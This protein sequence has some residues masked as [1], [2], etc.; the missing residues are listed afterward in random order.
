MDW[1]DPDRMPMTRLANTAIDGVTEQMDEV[2]QAI[3]AFAG[4]D[5]LCYRAEAPRELAQKQAESWDPVLDWI[6]RRFGARFEIGTGLGHVIQPQ[7]SINALADYLG[8]KSAFELAPLHVL[9]SLTGSIFLALAVAERRFD[10]GQAW[11]VAHI[12]EDWQMAQWGEDGEARS[13]RDRRFEDFR[14]AAEFLRLL[15]Q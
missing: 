6:D 13:R 8:D 5:L 3:L 14:A 2:R 4:S 9:T 1:I 12:D 10:V 7:E 11:A 15:D